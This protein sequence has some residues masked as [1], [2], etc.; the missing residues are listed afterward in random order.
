M[1]IAKSFYKEGQ[2]QG[3]CQRSDILVYVNVTYQSLKPMY[4]YK[5]FGGACFNNDVA[6]AYVDHSS[7]I[8][9]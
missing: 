6:K 5:R 7:L 9:S 2:G 3:Q 1:C 4:G 8:S